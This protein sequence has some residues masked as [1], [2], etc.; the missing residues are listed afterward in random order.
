M[1]KAEKAAMR[2]GESVTVP[3]PSPPRV[4]PVVRK[5]LRQ[6]RLL[7]LEIK[8][9]R[10]TAEDRARDRHGDGEPEGGEVSTKRPRQRLQ[11][12]ALHRQTPAGPPGFVDFPVGAGHQALQV[13]TQLRFGGERD[14]PREVGGRALVEIVEA[15]HLRE[16][17]AGVRRLIDTVQHGLQLGPEGPLRLHELSEVDDHRSCLCFTDA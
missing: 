15:L 14:Q 8:R 16:V 17:Q 6:Q 2:A 12:P 7:G 3:R 1:R 4:Q 5:H 10:N 9:D 13:A 11:Q